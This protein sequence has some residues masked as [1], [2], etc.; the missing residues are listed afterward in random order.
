MI[1]SD[2]KA[3]KGDGVAFKGEV[4]AMGRCLRA[5]RRS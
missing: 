3:L 1:G 5:T 4:K 2:R